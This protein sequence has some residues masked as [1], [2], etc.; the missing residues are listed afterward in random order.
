MDPEEAEE[1]KRAPQHANRDEDE[2][3]TEG[4]ENKGR[5]ATVSGS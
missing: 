1:S 4:E 5:R 3:L 2:H